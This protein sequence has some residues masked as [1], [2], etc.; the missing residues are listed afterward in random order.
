MW[1][2]YNNNNP[3][4]KLKNKVEEQKMKTKNKSFKRLFAFLVALVMVTAL[5]PSVIFAADP[6]FPDVPT[7]HWAYD[8]IEKLAKAEIIGG[9]ADGTFGPEDNVTRQQAAKMI[10]GAA[11]LEAGINFTSKFTDLD[12]VA[13]E[14]KPFVLALEENKVAGGFADGSFGPTL[15]IKRSQAAKMIVKAFGIVKGGTAVSFAD[16]VADATDQSY[17]D[18]L[19]SNGIVKGYT[20]DGKQLFKPYNLVTRAQ[21]AKMIVEAMS[22]V[23]STFRVLDVRAITTTGVDVTFDALAEDMEDTTIEVID[24]NGNVVEVKPLNL[25]INETI[26]NF[27][28]KTA[29]T[30]APT[31]VWTVAG[32]EYDADVAAQLA[33]INGATTE[34]GLWNALEAAGIKNLVVANSALYESELPAEGFETL[35]EVQDYVDEVNNSVLDE[36]ATEEVMDEINAALAVPSN[37]QLLAALKPFARVNEDF[38]ASYNG[39]ATTLGSIT[40]T[41]GTTTMKEVQEEIDAVNVTQVGSLIGTAEGSAKRADYDK[42]LAAMVFVRADDAEATPADTVKADLQERLVELNLIIKVLEAKTAAQFTNAYN[43]LVTYVDDETVIGEEDYYVGLRTEY[44]AQ[45][46]GETDIAG[47]KEAI[48]KA[49][50]EKRAKLYNDI[51]NIDD[52]SVPPTKTSVVLS[53]LEALAAYLPDATI[54]DIDDVVTTESRLKD[55]R[56]AL[57]ALTAIADPTDFGSTASVA[58]VNTA[59]GSV[60]GAVTTVNGT[61]VSGPLAAIAAF[62]PS[63][64]PTTDTEAALLAL[65]KDAELALGN[66]VDANSAAY[67]K[68]E[69]AI[70]TA[71]ATKDALVALIK[72]LNQVQVIANATT[73]AGA[74]AA[75]GYVAIEEDTTDFINLTAAQKSEVADLFVDED[76]FGASAF[77]GATRTTATE[78]KDYTNTTDVAADLLAVVTAY[79]NALKGVNVTAT[80][81]NTMVT[82]LGAIEYKAFDDLT[83]AQKIDVADYF[84]TNFPMTNAETPARVP[85]KTF[86]AIEADV[87]AAIAAIQ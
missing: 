67:F 46:V 47:I 78:L 19:A 59:I 87:D 76:T 34:L 79:T 1:N 7:T 58:A 60:Q 15:N 61:A 28:F 20:E 38:V 73:G 26:G 14:L 12:K 50:T 51:A 77:A 5:V 27:E 62:D 68:E 63:T 43:A 25:V 41:P 18:I 69:S 54:F 4:R 35:V 39:G 40:I 6:T 21:L 81:N 82:A 56:T 31:G 65:L 2:W 24:N 80:A 53:R 10:A 84:L 8:Y 32:I 71:A 74:R 70:A 52:T 30:A 11:D 55:Y 17:I 66:V 33:A 13:A 45:V 75:L 42:A 85:Y 22:P 64:N 83:A 48:V 23:D 57:A 49:N 44:M 37:V 36:A 9:Y 29:L 72:D 86:T 3:V 16:P